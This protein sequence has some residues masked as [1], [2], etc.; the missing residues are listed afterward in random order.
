MQQGKQYR[1]YA[2]AARER[3]KPDAG[4]CFDFNISPI[5]VTRIAVMTQLL[6]PVPPAFVGLAIFRNLNTGVTNLKLNRTA[7]RG[8]ELFRVS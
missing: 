7:V 6:L 2:A 5:P 8:V 3:K 1:H 4:H